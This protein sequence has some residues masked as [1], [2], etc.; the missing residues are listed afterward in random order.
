MSSKLS[1]LVLILPEMTSQI[2]IIGGQ[3]RGRNIR[4][5]PAPG[6]RPTPGRVRETLFNWLG[7]T[8]PDYHCLDLF[9]GSGAL[10]FEALSRGAAHA[11][12]VEMSPSTA[13]LLRANAERLGAKGAEIVV[14]DALA[15]LRRD[16]RC[17]D[18]I[19]LDPPFAANL[20]EPVLS[21]VHGRL[22]PGG[23]V[24]CE[25]AQGVSKS[26]LWREFRYSRAGQVVHQLLQPEPGPE[27]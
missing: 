3:W 27:Q 1:D 16:S 14:S 25:S 21:L 11:V 2:R 8:L 10:G 26:P 19:F 17:F 6:L 18:L 23:M 13:R 7:Q 15:W 5:E 22:N 24:Y 4:F 12:L 9:A 20:L